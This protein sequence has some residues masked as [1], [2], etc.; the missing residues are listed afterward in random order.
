MLPEGRRLPEVPQ[1]LRPDRGG[2]PQA[3][4]LDLLSNK[5]R[6]KVV[7]GKD[8]VTDAADRRLLQQEQGPL[9]AAREA[10]PARRPDQDE[11]QGRRRRKAALEG[12]ESLEV[13]RQEVLD[14]PGLQGPGRQA[15]RRG[16][17]QQEKALDDAVF[18]APQGQARRAR[19]R[20]SSAT[21]SSRSSKITPASQQTLTQAKPTIKQTL[22]VAE[23]AEGARQRSSRTSTKRWKDKTDCRDGLQDAGLQERPEG[24]A[25]A[26][27]PRRRHDDGSAPANSGG[28]TTGG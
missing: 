6:D 2:H 26:D 5:I 11:G 9:R 18:K 14:R 7:K 8:T 10:R 20:P 16:Q 12:G 3:R 13:G 4:Q 15:A 28:T 19:S 23:P 27:G 25:D 22:A 21:T 24:H 1:D 17:G